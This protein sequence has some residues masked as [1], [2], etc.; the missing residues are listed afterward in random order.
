MSEAISP[1][2]REVVSLFEGALEGVSFPQV[3]RSALLVGSEEVLERASRVAAQRL[4]LEQA[5]AELEASR[6]ALVVL[7]R[8]GV[9]YARVYAQAD[10]E[11]LSRIEGLELAQAPGAKRRRRRKEAKAPEEAPL[12]LAVAG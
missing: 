10:S 1:A 11:L 9:A 4:Q 5:Q 7:A 2:V 3:D 12:L 6:E 8:R